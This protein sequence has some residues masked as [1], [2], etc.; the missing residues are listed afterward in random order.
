MKV[1]LMIM[2]KEKVE[3]EIEVEVEVRVNS[4]KY[5]G[6]DCLKFYWKDQQLH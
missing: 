2:I 5:R 3:V 4:P 6:Q 1:K